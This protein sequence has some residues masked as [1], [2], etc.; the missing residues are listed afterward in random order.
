MTIAQDYRMARER[1]A[2]F[3]DGSAVL[4]QS[5]T[6]TDEQQKRKSPQPLHRIL[7]VDDNKDARES[8]ATL[9]RE[10][11]YF[12]ATAHDGESALE[13]ALK[14]KPHVMLLDVVMPG[15]SGYKVAERV[16]CN[17]SLYDTI[18]ITLTGF[19]QYAD[20]WLSEHV[21]CDYH[22]L[23]PLDPFVLECLL[24]GESPRTET[25]IDEA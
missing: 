6:E 1:N 17:P 25:Q 24:S 4:K 20:G 15:I 5:Q 22:L 8:T 7:V 23:K 12:V 21:G 9:L 19:T 16:R 3:A 10:F 18:L 11:G 13:R 2:W 14:F